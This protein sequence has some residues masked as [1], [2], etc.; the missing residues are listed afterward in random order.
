MKICLSILIAGLITCLSC[1]TAKKGQNINAAISVKDTTQRVVINSNKNVP[2]SLFIVKNIIKNLYSNQI[3]FNSF[4]AKV[5]VDY[6]DKNAGGQGTANIRMVKDSVIWISLTGP[7]NIEI[8][9]LLINK[10]SVKLI[11]KLQKT[12]SYRSIN[13]LHELTQIPLDLTSLQNIII[14]NPVFIDSTITSYKTTENELLILMTGK[15]FKNLI[16]L[17]KN[18]FKMLHSKLD[19][20]NT[21]QKRTC[22]L[23]YGSY[24]TVNNINFSTT[25]K[26]TVAEKEKLNVELVFK[27]YQ[28][29]QPLMFPFT[30][31]K[32]YT[33]E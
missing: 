1:H 30:I 5:R 10:D 33:R 19:D 7:L 17:T 26:I 11:N 31:P 28:F 3:N 13:Y 27:Q 16:T 15:I 20:V 9:R 22:D 14:G 12:S 8:F 4:S 18:D 25:R 2:D 21:A 24:E 32:N 29:N 23:T 6:E